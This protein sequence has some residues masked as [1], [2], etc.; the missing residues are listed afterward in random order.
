MVKE[1]K[2]KGAYIVEPPRFEDERGFFS[3]SWSLKELPGWEQVPLVE[4]NLSLSTRKGTLRGMH[5]QAAPHGQAKLVR[6]TRGRVYDVIIDLRPDSQTFKQWVGV[7]LSAEN[8]VTLCV[9]AEFAHGFQTLEDDSEVFYLVSDFYAPD[10][11]RGVR[12]DDP[13]FRIDWPHAERRVMAERDRT[14]P[15]FVAGNLT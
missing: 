5:Y 6:C 1:T 12:W 13:A 3:P 14:Y 7:E 8:R 9:P 4:S 2:L 10:L 15:D 11:G